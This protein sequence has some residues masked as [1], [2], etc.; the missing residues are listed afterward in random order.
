MYGYKADKKGG[1]A[2]WQEAVSTGNSEVLTFAAG[3]YYRGFGVEQSFK[4]SAQ[5]A[6][7]AYRQGS[8]NA[9]QILAVIYGEEKVKADK[10]RAAMWAREAAKPGFGVDLLSPEDQKKFYKSLDAIDPF[11][12]KIK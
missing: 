12:L 3:A 10:E 1:L 6:E 8:F 9:A 11:A 5:F 2:L 4:Q 7:A